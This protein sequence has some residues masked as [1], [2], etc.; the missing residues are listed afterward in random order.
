MSRLEYCPRIAHFVF[1]VSDGDR[2]KAAALLRARMWPVGRDERYRDE[3]APG[4]LAL[5]YVAA[6]ASAFVARV[7]LATAVREWTPAEAAACPGNA[8]GGVLLAHV[9]T[10]DPAVS[11]DAVVRRID[12]TGSNPIVQ[13]NASAGFRNGRRTDH[14]RR[15]RERCSD[16]PSR[17][18][19]R[20]IS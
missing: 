1:N 6:P 15:V 17:P 3:L 5:I 7:E 8:A 20:R 10:W 18:E 11:M 19:W 4:D 9:D 13:A 12:P 16:S 2:G 14:G